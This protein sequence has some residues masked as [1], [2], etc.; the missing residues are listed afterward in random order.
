MKH[1]ILI[2][3]HGNVRYLSALID[4][5]DNNFYIYVHLD[6]KSLFSES[7]LE[8]ISQKENVVYISRKYKINWGGYDLLKAELLL[9]EKA[10]KDNYADYYHF[11]SGQDIPVVS[12]EEFK[13]FFE[14]NKGREFLEYAQLPRKDWDKDTFDRIEFYHFYDYVNHKTKRGRKIIGK[15]ISFQKRFHIRRKLPSYFPALYGGSAWFSLSKEAVNYVV[16]FTSTAP[17]FLKRLR[18]T[19]A[20]DETYILTV[21]VNSPLRPNIENN[22]LRYIVWKL[23]NNS[24]PAILDLSDYYAIL[25]SGS[26]FARKVIL[27]ISG[28][29]VDR[30][31]RTT[32]FPGGK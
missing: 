18:C 6:K 27:P 32:F 30:L 1:A 31:R 13:L 17:A 11:I 2:L 26:L 25:E 22:N 8:E 10:C 16:D 20:P 21:L 19:F 28:R 15:A 14:K 23:R 3:A 7:E 29:L 5:F 24:F 4:Y 9:L 12:L